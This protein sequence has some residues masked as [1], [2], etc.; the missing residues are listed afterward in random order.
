MGEIK[1][2]GRWVIVSTGPVREEDFGDHID[3][4]PPKQ[5]KKN[6]NSM[7]KEDEG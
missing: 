5:K 3:E 7:P 4:F 6:H 2:K 1:K